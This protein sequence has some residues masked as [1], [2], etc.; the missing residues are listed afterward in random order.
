[1]V[2]TPD[3]LSLMTYVA[4]FRNWASEDARRARE[5]LARKKR[6]ADPSCCYAHGPGLEKAETFTPAHFEI[7]AKNCFDEELQHGGDVF[8]VSIHGPDGNVHP[9]VSDSGNGKYPVEYTVTKGGNYTISIKLRGE[10]IKGSPYHVHA[11]GPKAGNSYATGPGVEGA[12]TRQEAPFRVHSVDADGRPVKHGGDPFVVQVQGPEEVSD[13]HLKDN[14]DGTFDGS[15]KVNTPGYYFVNITLEDEPIKGSPY[16]VLI[17]AARAGNSWAEGPGLEGGQALKPG[18]FTIHAV[19]PD[20]N[21][22]KDGGDPFEVQIA[23]PEELKPHITDNHNGT[24]T[25]EYH[26]T[27]PGDYHINTTLH[28]EPIRDSPK[29][30]HIKPAPDAGNSWAEGPALHGLVD[31]E[32]GKFT[33]HAVDPDGNPRTDGGDDFR[34]NIHGPQGSVKPHVKDNND[35]TYDVE[36]DPAEPGNY[37]ISVDLEGK[38]PIKDSP[39]RV[40]CKEGTDAGNSGFGVFSFTIQSFDKRKEKKTF[41]GDKFEVKITASDKKTEIE[42]QCTDNNDGTYTCVYAVS[43]PKGSKFH[44]KAYLNG[45]KVGTFTQELKVGGQAS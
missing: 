27:V 11:E 17:E 18:V 4:A 2:N 21:A 5:E 7:V 30:V 36:F 13:P 20:G 34:V 43:G 29:K 10:D 31:N 39:W 15:Y 28:D 14:H 45:K 16:R 19:D 6:T 1:M 44:I 23:G 33:I 26:P 35:G 37:D 38:H 41:G 24:Y 40:K 22:R 32:P 3:E 42:T 8:D 25:V 12:R 9:Q